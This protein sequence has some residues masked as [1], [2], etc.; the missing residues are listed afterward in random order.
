MRWVL[1]V[2]GVL[3]LGGCKSA[4]ERASAEVNEDQAYCT[5]IGAQPGTDAFVQCR[6]QLRAEKEQR[7]A[8]FRANPPFKNDFQIVAPGSNRMDCRSRQ[9]FGETRT[10]CN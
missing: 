4:A 3:A 1:L 5:S 2:A 7:E 8:R 6:L 10:T 9:E